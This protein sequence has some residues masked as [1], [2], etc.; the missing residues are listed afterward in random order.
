[1]VAFAHYHCLCFVGDYPY[2][3]SGRAYHFTFYLYNLL[4][5]S[6]IP[7]KNN[8]VLVH[9]SGGSDSTLAAA[10]CAERFKKVHLVTYDRF[11][12]IGARD[13]T[14]VN[15]ERLCRIYGREKFERIIYPI[16]RWHKKI[17]YDRYI[18]FARKYKLAVTSLAFCK[19]SMHWYSAVYSIE[20]GIGTVADG[21]VPYMDLYPD[22][23]AKIS[24]DKLR[25]FYSEFGVRYEN[26]IYK[27]A[28]EVEQ[29]LYDK[30][31]TETPR[32]RGS[33]KDKQVFYA[34]QVVF[35]LFVKYYT[36]RHGKNTYET[37]LSN[38]FGEKIDFMRQTIAD[39]MK[40][41]HGSLVERLKNNH[42]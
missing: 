17:C 37:V 21:V 12:F 7:V 22:Q 15:F 5:L 41:S 19:L 6:L 3:R 31:I 20:N 1:M 40:D 42:A 13:Y 26:P 28:D 34:E 10:L 36:E 25:D 39:W 35:A 23:N 14:L 11:S 33:E 8:F 24:L 2:Y 29:L 4:V 32:I 9:F 18:Y 38:L 16:G 30:G 27:I